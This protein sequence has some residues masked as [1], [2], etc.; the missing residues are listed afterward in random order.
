MNKMDTLQ[1]LQTIFLGVTFVL[2]I[3]TTVLVYKIGVTQ[4]IINEKALSISDFA[5]VFLM[6]QTLVSKMSDG[7]EKATGWNILIKNVSAYP[8]YLNSYVLNGTKYDIGNSAIPNNSDSW[9]SVPIPEDV[10]KNKS[11][12]LVVNFEDYQG[13]KYQTEGFGQFNVGGWSIK[14]YRRVLI[15]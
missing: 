10:Q 15:K 12:S 13:N 7:S 4:N 6:P 8:I 5:E 11:F 2:G 9:F 14:S 1:L 3:I